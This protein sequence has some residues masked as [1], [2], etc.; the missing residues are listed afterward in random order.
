M[1]RRIKKDADILLSFFDEYSLSGFSTNSDRI[2]DCR[3]IHKKLYA[4]MVFRN[5]AINPSLQLC[6]ECI[7]YL[8][9]VISDLMLGL[10]SWAQ[11]AYKSSKLHLRCSI[12]NYL[13]SLLSVD[14]PAIIVEKRVYVIFDEAEND[15]HFSTPLGKNILSNLK[16]IYGILC[17]VVHSAPTERRPINA[18]NYLPTYDKDASRVFVAQFCSVLNSFLEL[19]FLQYHI[20]V[21]EMHPENKQDYLEALSPTAIKTITEYLYK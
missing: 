10:F 16:N 3:T 2:R 15:N 6:N 1:S 12:E 9:E 13:K 18:I 17:A 11:G 21:H 7:D 19:F 4:F 20:M 5:E 8:D 14:N